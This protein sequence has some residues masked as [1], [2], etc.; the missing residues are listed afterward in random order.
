MCGAD[1]SSAGSTGRP[2]PPVLRLGPSGPLAG[3][4]DRDHE[5]AR[6]HGRRPTV[7]D[8][9]S[10][11]PQTGTW[12][13]SRVSMRH[14]R[15]PAGDERILDS[16]TLTTGGLHRHPNRQQTSLDIK[17]RPHTALRPKLGL[18]IAAKTVPLSTLTA[19]TR[20][21]DTEDIA[22]SSS[23]RLFTAPDS[24]AF[25]SQ[26]M[27]AYLPSDHASR[28]G[29]GRTCARA[30]APC[31]VEHPRQRAQPPLSR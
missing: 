30:V 13:Q 25:A 22:L 28:K 5:H 9:Q 29:P 24:R 10:G 16:S 3:R 20:P 4:R 1:R 7:L 8:N 2:S 6:R 31:R 21:T 15:P 18:H 26:E 27:P 12:S 19:G 11:E 23:D 17:P 14:E